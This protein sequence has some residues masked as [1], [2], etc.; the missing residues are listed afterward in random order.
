MITTVLNN[1]LT[2]LEAESGKWLTEN[3]PTM[4]RRFLKKLVLPTGQTAESWRDA[5]DDEKQS[6]TPPQDGEG[7]RTER[8]PLYEATGQV[9]FND[10]T[11]YYECNGYTDI[12]EEEMARMYALYCGGLDVW[13]QVSYSFGKLTKN[14]TPRT[15][16]PFLKREHKEFPSIW[17]WYNLESVRFIV[18]NPDNPL[19]MNYNNS[20]SI[21][22]CDSL[23]HVQDILNASSRTVDIRL[24]SLPLLSEIRIRNCKM[25]VYAT[26]S[27]LIS[28]A[29][30]QYLIENA[31]NTVARTVSV[32]PDVYAK[33]ADENNAEWHAV[34]TA[35]QA[36]QISFATS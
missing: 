14:Y 21:G 7:R 22:Y 30:L 5:E 4:F 17:W 23:S 19:N 29:S 24:D 25:D 33:L 27:P 31:A 20:A 15:T 10:S 13:N 8:T 35:A 32:H 2:Q 18:N 9:R 6:F 12:G 26:G 16:I 36:R 34:W 28:L 3:F 1:G 11:G